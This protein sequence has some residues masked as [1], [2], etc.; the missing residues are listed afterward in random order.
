MTDRDF[1]AAITPNP[2]DDAPRLVYADWLEEHDDPR[3]EFIRV[4]VE[5][6]RRGVV[7][8]ASCRCNGCGR[9]RGAGQT[10][11]GPCQV[12]RE[13]R[14]LRAREQKLMALHGRQ[15]ADRSALDT[16]RDPTAWTFSRGF[17]SRVKCSVTNWRLYGGRI[18]RATPLE[19]VEMSGCRPLAPIEIRSWESRDESYSWSRPRYG[20]ECMT[21]WDLPSWLMDRMPRR[22]DYR[23]FPTEAAA[24]AALSVAAIEWAKEQPE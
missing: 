24:M 21:S 8:R 1:L 4:Q 5:I 9:R 20:D 22:N 2:A 15:W 17:I 7:G 16:V 19:V 14:P 3:G 12:D 13:L 6:V 11:N 18:V 10:H 23:G